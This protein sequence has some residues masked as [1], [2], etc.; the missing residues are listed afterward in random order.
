M[1]NIKVLIAD[2]SVVYRSQIRAALKHLEWIEVVGAASNGKLALDKIQ[3]SFVD[4]LILDL[5]MPE[6]DGIQ[7]L[8]EIMKKGIMCKV[9]VFSS[10]SKKGAEVTLE[11]LRLGASDFIAKPGPNDFNEQSSSD[12]NPSSKIRE[13]LEPK[14]KALFPDAQEASDLLKSAIPKS[15]KYVQMLW[16]LFYPKVI[17]IGSSTGGPTV[18]ENIFSALALPLRCPILIAQ[19]MPPIFTATL[20]A[21]L[22]KISGINV[23]EAKHDTLLEA[24]TV[25][26]APGN[27]HMTLSGTAGRASISLNQGPLINSVRPAVDPLFESAASIYKEKCLGIVLTGMGADGKVGAERIKE[28]G[29]GVIIQNESSCVVFGMPGAVMSSGAYDRVLSPS[30]II[31]ALQEKATGSRKPV[32]KTLS[33]GM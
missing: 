24:D 32:P 15:S 16:E 30:E 1:K 4:L 5:E 6:M 9:L 17:V 20:A 23:I 21:R 22:Q 2:D 13:L 28:C 18:L 11:A 27:Y 10:A 8:K 14:I 3:Q 26:M 12:S 7:T 33:G 31:T 19:H 25:Y 29:G